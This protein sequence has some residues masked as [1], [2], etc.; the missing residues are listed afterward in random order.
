MKN[1]LPKEYPP[2]LYDMI[3]RDG[4]AERK[5]DTVYRISK[6]GEI[7]RD[8]FLSTFQEKMRE[9]SETQNRDEQMATEEQEEIDIGR[10]ST[11]CFQIKRKAINI[12]KLKAK[13]GNFPC[14]L[15]GTIFPD[16]GLS[17]LTASSNSGRR[18]TKSH[19]DWWIYEGKD[20]SN[21][22]DIDSEDE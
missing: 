15:K 8:A 13:H 20:P 17:M 14:L 2:I 18:A 16:S 1:R 12:L 4:G 22:F 6:T 7:N 9:E 5:F 10:F 19:I 3:I 11:S 21:C